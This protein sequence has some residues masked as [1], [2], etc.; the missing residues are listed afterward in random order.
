MQA[1]PQRVV[2]AGERSRL[3]REQVCQSQKLGNLS[4]IST[5][6]AIEIAVELR[7]IP[8]RDI[9]NLIHIRLCGWIHRLVFFS[10]I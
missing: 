4:N 3:P 10:A 8:K 9:Y 5:S 2:E 6:D 7:G 1:T